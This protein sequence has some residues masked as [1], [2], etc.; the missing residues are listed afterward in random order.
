MPV[1][2]VSGTIE[3]SS[4]DISLASSCIVVNALTVAS[5][6]SS[7][8]VSFALSIVV[9]SIVALITASTCAIFGGGIMNNKIIYSSNCRFWRNKTF[10][11][12]K[13]HP[14]Y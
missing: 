2:P 14:L 7:S 6:Q 5:V 9:A 4:N 13:M 11:F 12:T 1:F 10:N 8:F 3:E